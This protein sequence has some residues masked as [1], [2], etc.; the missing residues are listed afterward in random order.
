MKEIRQFSALN[1]RFCVLIMKKD[2]I[3][4]NKPELAVV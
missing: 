4:V 2:I 1:S 3:G